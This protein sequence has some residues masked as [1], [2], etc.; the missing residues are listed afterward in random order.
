VAADASDVPLQLV[1]EP[2]PG[3]AGVCRPE[4]P[5]ELVEAIEQ[6]HDISRDGVS[7]P[8][9]LSDETPQRF[10]P[11]MGVGAKLGPPPLAQHDTD[12]QP[13]CDAP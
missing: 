10:V 12:P 11:A 4:G 7:S 6:K 2:S 9:D 13:P 1:E 8:R 3:L 5:I